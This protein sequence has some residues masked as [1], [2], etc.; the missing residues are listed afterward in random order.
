MLNKEQKIFLRRLAHDLKTIL[1]VG[2]N[3]LT[4]NVMTEINNALNHHE[5]VKI[6]IRV[7]ER[8]LRDQTAAEIARATAAE[9]VQKTGNTIVLFRRNREQPKIHLPA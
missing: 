8:T 3:G 1:W 2:Q 7:G 5:L 6:K 4:E 9:T